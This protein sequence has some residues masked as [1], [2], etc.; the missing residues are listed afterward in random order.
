MTVVVVG[1]EFGARDEDPGARTLLLLRRHDHV[2]PIALLTNL[3]RHKPARSGRPLYTPPCSARRRPGRRYVARRDGRPT[4]LVH[5]SLGTSPRHD[6]DMMA[7]GGARSLTAD[8][9]S[10]AES[11]GIAARTVRSSTGLAPRKQ[12]KSPR[13]APTTRRQQRRRR[14]VHVD[15]IAFGLPSGTPARPRRPPSELRRSIA[16]LRFARTHQPDPRSSARIPK[17]REKRARARPP[18]CLPQ[19]IFRTHRTSRGEQAAWA[20]L[21]PTRVGA[22]SGALATHRASV[23]PRCSGSWTPS[24]DLPTLFGPDG[25]DTRALVCSITT[26]PSPGSC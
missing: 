12:K 26:R 8:G 16:R 25:V 18:F 9:P 24:P 2:H 4:D 21:L 19:P 23:L 5:I 7:V 15:L 17:R 11:P 22:P 3:W 1:K 10:A 13:A 6:A 14:S 20:L